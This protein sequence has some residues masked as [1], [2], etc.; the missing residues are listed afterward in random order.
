MALSRDDLKS[1]IKEE[2]SRVEID[3]LQNPSKTQNDE[4]LYEAIKNAS[5]SLEAVV[6]SALPEYN[7]VADELESA[8]QLLRDA[9]DKLSVRNPNHRD[10]SLGDMD[11]IERTYENKSE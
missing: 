10:T 3:M 5:R 4:D 8:A 1:L 6:G 11:R 2:L 7:G 9:L